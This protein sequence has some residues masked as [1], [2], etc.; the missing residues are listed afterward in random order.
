MEEKK[1]DIK[2]SIVVGVDSQPKPLVI[3]EVKILL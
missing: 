3:N 2:G 1:L